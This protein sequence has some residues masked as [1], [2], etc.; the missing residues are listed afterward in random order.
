MLSTTNKSTLHL[1]ETKNSDVKL[2]ITSIQPTGDSELYK[3]KPQL[4]I[5]VSDDEIK[6]NDW[7]YSQ[8]HN[9]VFKCAYENDLEHYDGL[10]KKVVASSDI[11]L[12]PNCWITES[13][14]N[15]YAKSYNVN[16]TIKE[17]SIEVTEDFD[18][19]YYTPAG[20]IECARKTNERLLIKTREDGSVIIHKNKTYSEEEVKN[21]AQEA[22]IESFFK[23][24]NTDITGFK[25]WFEKQLNN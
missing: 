23:K 13:F 20:G 16:E 22:W 15:A 5:I 10:L 9:K 17:V 1:A 7:F 6:Q 8:S 3:S 12:T 11:K 4:L 19:E 18:L 24:R 21:I 25:E 2:L 14:I